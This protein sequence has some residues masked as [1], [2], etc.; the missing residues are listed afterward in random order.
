MQPDFLINIAILTIAATTAQF[1]PL[2]KH[3]SP[4]NLRFL[5]SYLINEQPFLGLWWLLAISVPTLASDQDQD[6]AAQLLVT[7]IV[8]VPAAALVLV[9]ALALAA[10]PALDATL[11]SMGATP[12]HRSWW[13]LPWLRLLFVPF[14]SWSP[15]VRRT[16]NVSYGPQRGQRLDIYASRRRVSASTD[17]GPV[18]I[19]LH[20]GGFR[21]GSKLLGGRALIY[22]L[23]RHGWVCI[24]ADYRIRRGTRFHEQ[25]DDARAVLA[26]ARDN[27]ESYHG[28]PRTVFLAGGSAGAH[29]ASTTAL[30]DDNDE[31]PVA[32][33]IGLYGYYGPAD[34]GL[35]APSAPIAYAHPQAPPFLLVHGARD[36]LVLATDARDFADGLSRIST[37]PVAFALLP[38][39]QHNFD[40]FQSLRIHAVIDAVESFAAWV[41]GPGAI[42]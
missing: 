24:G 9:G 31:Q 30:S 1:A 14:I 32:G 11:R 27:V 36:C 12:Q 10:R 17:G 38:G 25:L 23:A 22:H 41:T 35:D 6:G 33:V 7:G 19:Y 20:G 8:A 37:R 26:W 40:Q 5:L 2:P 39:A 15:A 18:L 4:W 29:L 34:E 28:D 3:S 16:A 21:M 42:R 13:R